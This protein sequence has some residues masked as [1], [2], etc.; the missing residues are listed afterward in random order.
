MGTA[1]LCRLELNVG[2]FCAPAVKV[3]LML[4]IHDCH[5]WETGHNDLLFETAVKNSVLRKQKQN[6]ERL[7]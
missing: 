6:Q 3:Y 5:I 2:L 1:P 7:Q 4:Q